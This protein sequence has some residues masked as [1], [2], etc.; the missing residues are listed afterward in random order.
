MN[1]TISES[2]N[3]LKS[4]ESY[5]NAMLAK[6]FDKMASY[7]HDNIHFIAPLAEMHGKEAV[8]TAA[9]NF[10]GILQDIRIRSR[11][12]ADNQ[13]CLLTIWWFLRLLVSSGQQYLWNLQIGLSLKSS[14]FTMAG[15]LKKR[16]VKF[17]RN[18]S[19]IQ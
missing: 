8:V 6:D 4:A 1:T 15:P 9:K 14:Y 3:N 2:D 12:A 17:S 18:T 13:I 11:F 16:K 19:V 10:G 5:Y 7:L